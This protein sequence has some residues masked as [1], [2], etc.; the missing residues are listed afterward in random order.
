LAVLGHWLEHGD[1]S[2][3]P[4]KIKAQQ[5]NRHTQQRERG[6]RGYPWIVSMALSSALMPSGKILGKAVGQEVLSFYTEEG[7]ATG[8]IAAH[9]PT[10]AGVALG[11]A[12]TRS[13]PRWI[14]H[15]EFREIGG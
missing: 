10:G 15:I 3:G 4:K 1:L 11:Q 6:E 2:I 9:E 8:N 13:E 5:R 12:R 14:E 7:R